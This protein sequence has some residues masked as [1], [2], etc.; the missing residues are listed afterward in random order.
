LAATEAQLSEVR[1]TE[2]TLSHTLLT[3]QALTDD[4]KAAAHRDAELI[5]KEAELR[6]GEMLRD[7]RDELSA[8]QRELLDLRKQRLLGLERLRATLHTFARMLEIEEDE[9]DPSRAMRADKL[10]DR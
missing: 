7:A 2:Q 1:K 9:D 8:L 4:L 6:A 10:A 3:T 5:V